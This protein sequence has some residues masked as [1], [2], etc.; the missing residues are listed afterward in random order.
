VLETDEYYTIVEFRNKNPTR[1]YEI[2]WKFPIRAERD[3]V[4]WYIELDQIMALTDEKNRD[5]A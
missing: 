2:F 4:E 3:E 1:A 5:T